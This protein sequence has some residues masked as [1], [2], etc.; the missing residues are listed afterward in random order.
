LLGTKS[1]ATIRALQA[2]IQRRADFPLRGDAFEAL[3]RPVRENIL[4]LMPEHW[5]DPDSQRYLVTGLVVAFPAIA[6]LAY[7]GVRQIGRLQLPAGARWVLRVALVGAAL[8]PLLLNFVGWD[9]ARWNAICVL[10]AFTCL[11][12]LRL[13]VVAR[14]AEPA[15]LRADD[16]LTLS[17]AGLAVVLGLVSTNYRGFL[18]DG[19]TVQ[20][21]PFE[22]QWGSF[23]DLII[24]LLRGGARH[25]P[26]A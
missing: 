20:W 5:R 23:L 4:S 19:Y 13:L 6:F 18:F 16:T 14:A 2:S 26:R 11:L 17:L 25:L 12:C 24:N 9:S 8:A 15:R 21:F 10:A 22:E 7:F 1:P 3:Y